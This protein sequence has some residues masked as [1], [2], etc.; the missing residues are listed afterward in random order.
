MR[1]NKTT[2]IYDFLDYKLYILHLVSTYP[3]EGRGVF[4]KMA[5]AIGVSSVLIS[6]I[7]KG[8]KDLQLDHAIGVCDFFEMTELETQYFIALLSKQRAGNKALR[9]FYNKQIYD[10]QN[11]ALNLKSYIKNKD[12]VSEEAKSEFYSTWIYAAIRQSCALE[13]IKSIDDLSELYSL[14]RDIVE[15]KVNFMLRNNLL[16]QTDEGLTLGIGSTHI[17]KDSPLVHS[18]RKNWRLKAIDSFSNHNPEDLFFVAPM[19]ISEEMADKL[20]AKLVSYIK[21][22]YD[23]AP[24]HDPEVTCCLNIDLFRF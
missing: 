20:R 1:E 22:L 13:E 14:A 5:K 10:I 21:E 18:H 23:E 19:V 9:D 2:P 12:E 15:E 6:Q 8:S 24:K 7:F 11:Q 17:S 16:S 4:G 3:K